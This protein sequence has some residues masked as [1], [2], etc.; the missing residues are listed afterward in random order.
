MDLHPRCELCDA[1]DVLEQLAELVEE[2]GL[3]AADLGELIWNSVQHSHF[4]L[5]AAAE[6][7]LRD[8][9]ASRTTTKKFAAGLRRQARELR[10]RASVGV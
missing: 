7:D 10:E 8:L 5:S 6:R 2:S 1:A 9:R 3:S 4:T